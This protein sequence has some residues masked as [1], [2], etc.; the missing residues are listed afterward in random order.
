MT[1]MQDALKEVIQSSSGDDSPNGTLTL[2]QL[3]YKTRGDTKIKLFLHTGNRKSAIERA[4]LHCQL[5][6]WRFV[7]CE[8]AIHDLDLE[9]AK[10]LAGE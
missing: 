4:Q 9:E 2:Y 5:M 10:V 3:T 7:F 8:H 1:T 6:A